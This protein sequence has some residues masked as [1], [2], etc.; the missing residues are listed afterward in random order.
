MTL[1]DLVSADESL[2]G[3]LV[4]EEELLLL[5]G[6][7]NDLEVTCFGELIDDFVGSLGKLAANEGEV[8]TVAQIGDL[9]VAAI[10]LYTIYSV[11]LIENTEQPSAVVNGNLCLTH[12]LQVIVG[13]NQLGDLRTEGP[14]AG[15][16]SA[17][18]EQECCYTNHE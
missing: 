2:L 7:T 3:V 18:G 4:A 14:C 11:N 5:R 17:A 12:K 15:R 10:I 16:C 9:L 6:L 8:D 1:A 13:I